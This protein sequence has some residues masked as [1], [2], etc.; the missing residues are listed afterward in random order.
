MS[1][2]EAS[3]Q[4]PATVRVDYEYG[5]LREVIVGRPEGFRLPILSPAGIAE[6]AQILPP[7]EVDFL[8]RGQ[9][10]LL[11]EYAPDVAAQL[12]VQVG[13]L[14]CILESRGIIVHRPR[15]LTAAEQLFPG[16]GVSGGSLFFMRDPILVV[17][18]RII[19]LAMRFDFR[20]RQRFALREIIE[21]RSAADDVQFLSMPEPVPVAP[22]QGFGTGAFLEGGDVLLNGKEIYVGV[23]GHASS[24]AGARWLQKL[25]RGD[26]KVHVVKLAHN[27]L[28]LD[29]ALSIP[30]PGLVI[31]C[32]DSLP[33]GLPGM[34]RGWDV[35]DVTYHE[36][37]RL[38]C[39]GLILDMDT[40]VM[41]RTHARVAELLVRRNVNVIT[42]PFDLPARFGG[43]LRCT[44]HP[45]VRD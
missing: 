22:E 16:S 33:E 23:S 14:I 31:A 32:M 25:V 38:A 42:S 11:V 41:D 44:H 45:L 4:A 5:A 6:Y 27:I 20:R 17:G 28:H 9:G 43:G 8:I 10:Q 26:A 15:P 40:Y 12:S 1:K 37:R 13:Q 3:S 35:I 2:A 18:S 30:R 34:L 19:D 21:S 36:A 39:N 7:A 24:A 29:C